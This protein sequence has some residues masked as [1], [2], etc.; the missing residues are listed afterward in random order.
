[1]SLW[2]DYPSQNS[3]PSVREVK[4]LCI[5]IKY[6][7]YHRLNMDGVRSPKFILALV[8]SCTHWLRP[9]HS[10][11]PP[12]LGSYTRALL[13]SKDRRHLFVSTCFRLFL[14]VDALVNLDQWLYV[15]QSHAWL[16]KWNRITV[17]KFIK[18]PTWTVVLA[19]S[20]LAVSRVRALSKYPPS[21]EW[22]TG[23]GL[24]T[25]YLKLKTDAANRVWSLCFYVILYIKAAEFCAGSPY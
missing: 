19:V 21:S 10:P 11:T 5:F 25:K 20:L 24:I 22:I 9:R 1:V 12:H 8:Y 2:D 16:N 23:E 4:S 14:V 15:L 18:L 6:A 13:V 17:E 3:L 7:L